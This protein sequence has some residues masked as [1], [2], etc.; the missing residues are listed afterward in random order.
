MQDRLHGLTLHQPWAWAIA[1]G[2]KRIE[3]RSWAPPEVFLGTRIAIHAGKTWAPAGGLF[4]R[5]R[6]T[7]YRGEL[8][9][10]EVEVTTAAIIAVARLAGVVQASDDPWFFGPFGWVLED[11]VAI[12]P[13]P[14]RGFQKLWRLPAD[15]E[16]EVE[17][18][19]AVA[20]GIS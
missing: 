3:N 9:P 10:D 6:L 11:V 7:E 19:V 16:A 13:V 15:V 1:A 5:E 20:R 12:A 8:L 17:R 2:Y 14:C 4:I 18:R